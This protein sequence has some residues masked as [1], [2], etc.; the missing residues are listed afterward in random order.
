MVGVARDDEVDKYSLLEQVLA[1]SNF[2]PTL[3][4]RC[5]QVGKRR[6]EVRVAI[7]PNISMML[8]RADLGT[9]TD[10][11]LVI[12]LL[13][14]LLGAGYRNLV[15][16]ESQNLYGNWFERRT[17]VDVAA[18]A[19]YFGSGGAATIPVRGGGVEGEVEL[20]DL[21]LDSVVHHCAEGAMAVGRAW[22]EADIRI[23]FAAMKSHF[24]SHYT[25]AAKN[26][27]GC[28]PLQ[29]KVRD[30]HC[31]Q[32]VASYTAR[33]IHDFPVHFS[34]VDAYAAAD[35]WMGVK[36]KAIF[37]KPHLLVAGADVVAVDDLG[38]RMMG[39]VPEQSVIFA[40]LRRLLPLPSYRVV[41]D[42]RP[43]SNW[44]TA[45]RALP[46]L[47]RLLEVDA[48]IM[49][50]GGAI[51]TG[52]N[53][54]CF[55]KKREP[56]PVKRALY[57]LSFPVAFACDIGIVRLSLRHRRWQGAVAELAGELPLLAGSAAL[58]EALTFLGRDDLSA[59]SEL[60]ASAGAVTFSGHYVSVGASEHVLPWRMTT[61]NLAAMEMVAEVD[62]GAGSRAALAIELGIVR[63][64]LAHLL[65]D[66]HGYPYCYR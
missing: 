49:E 65:D 33:L 26:I 20:A 32:L 62:A 44:R 42:S 58:R 2:F 19:G 56:S 14:L 61:A 21:S 11:F 39:L 22:V 46:A 59:L 51:A 48:T 50:F 37:A 24:Y 12:H 16:V 7:K 66:P 4:A 29:D 38:A 52:G 43:L 6:A 15:V 41:G 30:Y 57:W 9:Y 64:R 28:L 36:M 1:D 34:I 53:D 60:L 25:M 5:R 17:V 3:A 47:S 63:R 23:G 40:A 8:R 55:E 18:R 35:G 54:D 31:K 27:Y 13:R 45:P 10:S